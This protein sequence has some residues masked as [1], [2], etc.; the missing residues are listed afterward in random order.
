MGFILYLSTQAE[1][2]E[3]KK[4]PAR[5]A[6][7]PLLPGCKVYTTTNSQYTLQATS[8]CT[9]CAVEA[10][11]LLLAGH[12]PSVGLAEV[13]LQRLVL[14]SNMAYICPIAI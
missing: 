3:E 2:Q 9:P 12:E 11:L 14:Y 10:A 5:A 13:R 6:Q 1:Q 7:R 8:A 4:L